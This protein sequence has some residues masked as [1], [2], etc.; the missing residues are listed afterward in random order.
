M[1]VKLMNFILG[2][3]SFTSR[4]TQKVR[5]DEG[6]A[7]AAYSLFTDDPWTYGLFTASSQTKAEATGRALEL[8]IDLIDEMRREGPTE[9]EFERARDTY[10]NNHVFDYES[11]EGVVERLVRYEWQGRPLDTA[12]RDIERIEELKVDDIRQA[13]AE[14]LRSDALAILVVGDEEKF[15]RPLSNFGEV[16]VIELEE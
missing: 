10:L 8:I 1:A 14:Y 4:I 16:R 6:L 13:A 12:E 11:E 5:T 15:D 7:Y 3:G 9:E 2:G